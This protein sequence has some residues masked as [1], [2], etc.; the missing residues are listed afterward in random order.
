MLY[1]DV[2]ICRHPSQIKSEREGEFLLCWSNRLDLTQPVSRVGVGTVGTD[3]DN[4]SNKN[5]NNNNHNLIRLSE[6]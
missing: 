1:R 5:K 4:S 3:V 2:S 6:N